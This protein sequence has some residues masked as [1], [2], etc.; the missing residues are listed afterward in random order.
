MKDL[1]D[2]HTHSVMSGHAYS[3]FEEN[4]RAAKE[5]GLEFYG[6]SDHGPALVGSP[7]AIY[8]MNF[9][10]WPRHI[11]G[12]TIL[13][14]IELNILNEKG[15]VDLED[16]YLEGVDYA[17]VSLHTPTMVPKS[18]EEN[19]M[20][21]INAL[22]HTNVKIIGHP[23]DGKYP[24]DTERVVKAAAEHHVLIEVN[25][26]SLKPD[27][28]RLNSRENMK[29][30]LRMCMKYNVPVIMNSDAH[31]SFEVGKHIYCEEIVNEVNFPKDRIVN[32]NR[33][34]LKEYFPMAFEK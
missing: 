24:F 23:D 30:V 9:K 13:R 19:T 7:K 27:G 3:T 1:L 10:V 14:G 18:K 25:N 34:L 32:Y 2:V 6:L 29:E 20:A 21:Y 11:D 28:F 4:V 22:N 17:I 8:F 5:K 26:S 33:E 15:E 12:V 31:I 16:R